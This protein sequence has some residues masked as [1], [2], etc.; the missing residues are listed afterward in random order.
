VARCFSDGPTLK[1][2]TYD[3]LGRLIRTQSPFPT[4]QHAALGEVRSERFYYD[5]I[6]RIQETR[7]DPSKN[8][9]GAMLAGD[10]QVESAA[11]ASLQEA[12]AGTG[13]PAAAEI[14]LTAA[15]LTLENQLLAMAD[16]GPG[17]GPGPDQPASPVQLVR[18]YVWGPGDAWHPATVDE[19]LCYYGEGRE[20]YWPIQDSS[21]DVA[22][23]CV[24]GLQANGYAARVAAQQRYDAYGQVLSA[25]HLLPHAFLAVGH[26][27]LFYDRLDRGVSDPAAR[28]SAVPPQQRHHRDPAPGPLRPRPVPRPQPHDAPRRRRPQRHRPGVPHLRQPADVLNLDALAAG[29]VV[30]R[31]GAGAVHAGGSECDGACTNPMAPTTWTGNSSRNRS[32]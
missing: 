19:L 28:G 17:P 9:G 6:R 25:D 5:G 14:D 27:G 23:V 4:P 22:A 11:L 18:E 20:A 16:P 31:R 2:Y 3:G 24:P 7:L 12:K 32:V 10:P 29:P 8:L 21:G 26:K 30:R 13:D 15:P 1:H